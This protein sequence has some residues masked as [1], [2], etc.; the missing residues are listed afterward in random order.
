[1]DLN[2]S[3][4]GGRGGRINIIIKVA[5]SSN[6]ISDYEYTAQGFL[7]FFLRGMLCIL[8]YEDIMNIVKIVLKG[9]KI[10]YKGQSHSST[11]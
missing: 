5:C 7:F 9:Q 8:S 10:G 2:V 1:M 11:H 6:H 3:R 4:D